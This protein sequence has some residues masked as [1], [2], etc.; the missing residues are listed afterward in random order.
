MP[1]TDEL[2]FALGVLFLAQHWWRARRV[3][4]PA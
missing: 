4:S 1:V 3:L 2:G